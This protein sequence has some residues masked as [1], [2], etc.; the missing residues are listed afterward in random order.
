MVKIYHRNKLT[1]T[2]KGTKGYLIIEP[3]R[4]STK[5][6]MIKSQYKRL[7]YQ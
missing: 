2:S 3:Q 6:K 1:D 4:V 5:V 7:E